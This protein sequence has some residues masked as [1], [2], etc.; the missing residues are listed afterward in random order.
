MSTKTQLVTADELLLLPRGRF[1]YELVEGELRTMPPAG[2]E[3]GAV[4]MNLA[5]P[6]TLYVKAN[7]LGLVLAAETGYKLAANPDTVLAPDVAF[8]RRERVEQTGI[9]KGF[10]EGAP[11]LAVEVMSPGDTPKEV[12]EKAGKW[13]AAGA[14]A[15]WV[16]NPKRRTVTVYRSLKDATTLTEADELDGGE[17]VPGFR[18]RVS[19][20]FA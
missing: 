16:V 15:V 4:A 7:K 2:E 18:C 10:R 6:L 12:T 13:L 1:R 11:D 20:L 17:V 19:E 14:L 5:A 9:M 3:H 8:V